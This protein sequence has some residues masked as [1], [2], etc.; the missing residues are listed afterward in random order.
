MLIIHIYLSYKIILYIYNKIIL[1]LEQ[2][3]KRVC[4]IIHNRDKNAVQNMLYIV[5]QI[6]KTGK[7][8]EPFVRQKV[9]TISYPCKK[10]KDK[11]LLD[12]L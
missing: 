1:N 5:E 12:G 3:H 6:K 4:K 2:E 10:D 8:P 11:L 7:R 9:E